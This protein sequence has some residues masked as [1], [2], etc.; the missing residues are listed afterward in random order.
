VDP[1][2]DAPFTDTVIELL[3]REARQNLDRDLA[4]FR[5]KASAPEHPAET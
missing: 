4:A 1:A 2:A 3:V 5:E